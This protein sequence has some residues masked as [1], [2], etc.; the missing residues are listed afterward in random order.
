MENQLI[1]ALVRSKVMFEVGEVQQVSGK[2][3]LTIAHLPYATH[4]M[5]D[6]DSVF[7]VAEIPKTR[8]ND[9]NE[10]L[11]GMKAELNLW[12]ERIGTGGK[13]MVPVV[14]WTSGLCAIHQR[15]FCPCKTLLVESP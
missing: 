9:F 10:A 4:L 15:R 3:K 8:V 7:F 6:R 12:N 14:K 11:S 13:K 5:K 1:D 2:L